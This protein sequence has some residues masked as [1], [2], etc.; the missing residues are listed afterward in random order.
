[1]NFRPQLLCR[2]NVRMPILL[3]LACACLMPSIAAASGDW[4]GGGG[5]NNWGTG[6]NWG[7]NNAP[8]PG[9]ANDLYFATVGSSRYTPYNNYTSYDD[10]RAIYFVNVAPASF[11]IGGNPIDLWWKIHNDNW[12]TMTWNCDIAAQGTALELNPYSGDL[13]IGSPNIYNNGKPVYAYGANQGVGAGKTLIIS[14]NLQ[15]TG[16]LT[17]RQDAKVRITGNSAYTGSTAIDCGDLEI[18]EGG[19]V[20]GGII[21]VGTNGTDITSAR[22]WIVDANGG[23]IVNEPIVLS[24]SGSY[25]Y[26]LIGGN[27]TSGENEFSG[28][29]AV[30][31]ACT[32][33]A[34]S[35]GT[36]LFS[37]AIS[38][39]KQMYLTGPG[40][41]KM[42][43]VNT[44]SNRNN[45]QA[46]TLLAAKAASLPGYNAASKVAVSSG[47][48]LAVMAGGGS[49]WASSEIDSL[50][51][52]TTAAFA[53]GSKFG[54]EVS[55]GNS[56]SYAND[57]GTTQAGKEFVKSGAGTLTLSGVNT[58]SGATT[59][60]DG[61]L[62]IGGAGQLGSG[63][64]AGNIT[65]NAVLNYNSTAAQTLSGIISGTG[66]LEK[67][68]S[69]IL[70]LTGANTL[71]YGPVIY[72]GEVKIG[73]GGS[74]TAGDAYLGDPTTTAVAT[75]LWIES[76]GVSFARRISVNAGD[77]GMRVAGGLNSSGTA[78]FSAN[79]ILFTGGVNLTANASGGTVEYT[80]V[81][82]GDY[83]ITMDGAG[84]VK[85]SNANT[86]SGATTVNAG[87]L[88]LGAAGVIPNG[89]GKGDVTVTDTTGGDTLDLGGF[90]ET[91]NGLSGAGYVDNTVAGGPY[92]LTV[93]DNNANSTFSGAIKNTAGTLALSKTGS[94]TLTLSGGNSYAG[95][96]AI[97][98]GGVLAA[99]HATALG[100]TAG[101]VTVAAGA[102]LQLSGTITIGAEPLSLTGTGISS[103][104]ALRN[105]ANNNTY[106]G[107]I[108]LAAVSRINSDA[109]TLTLDVASGS[110]IAGAFDL[111]LGGAGSITI[112]D[113]VAIDTGTLTKDGVGTLTLS[114][115]NTFSGVFNIQA[116]KLVANNDLALGTTAGGVSVTS[117]AVLELADSRAIGAE[118]LTL[119]GTGI[120]NGGAL[121][122]TSG[123]DTYAGKITLASTTRINSEADTLTL[124]V[125][126]GNAI[127]GEFGLTLGGAGILTINDPIATGTGTLTKDGSG[128]L[129]LSG[130]NTFSGA[131]DISAG[132]MVANNNAALGTTAG[133]VSVTSGA[134]LELA[135]NRTIGAEP[136]TLNGSGPSSGGAL[137][138]TSGNNTYQ[139]P[140]TLA[141]ATRIN[142]DAG[143]L[144]LDVASGNAIGGTYNLTLGGAGNISINDPIATSTGTLTKDG[145]G[146]LTLSGANSYSGAT[147]VNGGTL[148]GIGCGSS[149]TT[150]NSATLAPGSSIGTFNTAALTMN[151]GSSV[152]WEY[153]DT[154]ADKVAAAGTLTLATSA[155][156]VT[157]K[158]KK[159]ETFINCERTLFT[160]TGSAPN[161]A[162]L[163]FDLTDA[164]GVTS[165]TPYI[166]TDNVSVK[167]LLVPEPGM[168]ALAGLLLLALRKR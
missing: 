15:G 63:S 124:D 45:I 85:L 41:V 108:T 80:G 28:T 67:R 120:S 160:F 35:G 128:T 2:H 158:V 23:T 118:T 16:S 86:Y 49:E 111:T 127:E 101:G 83:P 56:F 138:N 14:G 137:R 103:G 40:T 150:V 66:N 109:G 59:I 9:S 168:L 94:G 60:S 31:G 36:L 90:S 110:A 30:D 147:T 68:N 157:I 153:N 32:L 96:T 62:T 52:A 145:A 10:W 133:G 71:Q 13:T 17:I 104:G 73:T 51:G 89:A 75:K 113:P 1:M 88:K 11:T 3:L 5:D 7:D 69:G 21:Y 107:A 130:A 144:T 131:L 146:T 42:T 92:T 74:I 57:I 132:T 78:T 156:A 38:G 77:A 48:K 33:Y 162:G 18:A 55:T 50:L 91:I 22:L 100:T 99:Q 81:I 19:A 102:A 123:N 24:T 114:G 129:T 166:G 65:D 148:A 27:N 20:G 6:A 44:Y 161:L 163:K 125:A 34:N 47:A 72:A 117:G 4:D 76:G 79:I 26:R 53:S 139:G 58:Y 29:V 98:G 82:S 152:D 165:A 39:I 93:G 119:N 116:G 167:V 126:S 154:T 84:V 8:A 149:A 164:L 37:G 64:Y 151:S 142:A 122:N 61:T 134:A 143:S 106:G 105:T 135:G 54:I 121:R 95:A 46:G 97:S 136:L 159:T 115:A 70:T 155:N 43:G 12:R 87:T 141:L 112:N 140:I 25:S